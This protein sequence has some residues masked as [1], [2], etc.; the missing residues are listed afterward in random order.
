MKWL[1][2]YLPHWLYRQLVHLREEKTEISNNYFFEFL[3]SLV[4]DNDCCD[5]LS[6]PP[7]IF[8]RISVD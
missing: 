8:P 7:L 3:Y 5:S 4:T 2:D 1:S 6:L